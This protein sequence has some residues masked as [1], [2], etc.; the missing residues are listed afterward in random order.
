MGLQQSSLCKN[1]HPATHFRT[2]DESLKNTLAGGVLQ[3]VI[4]TNCGSHGTWEP[5]EE[6]GQLLSM[7]VLKGLRRTFSSFRL[8]NSKL[9]ILLEI[10]KDKKT[11]VYHSI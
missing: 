4:P 10:E 1:N 6:K 5:A 7:E 8:I 11:D 9:R 3:K 2:K